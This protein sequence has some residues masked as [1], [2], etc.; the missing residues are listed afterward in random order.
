MVI[1]F[2]YIRDFFLFIGGLIKHIFDLLW[3]VVQLIGEYIS[4]GISI[5]GVF[6]SIFIVFGTV[7]LIVAVLYKILGREGAN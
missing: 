5:I 2:Y 1:I 3:S 7:A 4:I 6:P